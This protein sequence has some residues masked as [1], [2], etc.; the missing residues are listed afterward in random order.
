[1]T[2]A[3]QHVM[4]LRVTVGPEQVVGQTPQGRL[5]IIPITGGTFEGVGIRGRVCP[6]GADWNVTAA[7]SLSHVLARYWLEADDGAV[8]AVENEGWLDSGDTSAVW[9]TTPRFQC[10]VNGKYASLVTGG[11]V[12]ELRGVAPDRV[13]IMVW[14][15]S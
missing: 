3:A 7:G 8:I 9:R 12:G 6:G 4:T 11:Y 10:D 15:L 1:M 2:F 14:R 5:V 13:E